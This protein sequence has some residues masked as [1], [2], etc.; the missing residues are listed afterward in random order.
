MIQ[1]LSI[2][3]L[4]GKRHIL[5]ICNIFIFYRGRLIMSDLFCSFVTFRKNT[6]DYC[7]AIVIFLQSDNQ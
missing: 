1:N 7:K 6:K 3:S 5:F 2:V 4:V